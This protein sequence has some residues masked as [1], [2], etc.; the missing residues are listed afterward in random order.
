MIWFA[1]LLVSGLSALNLLLHRDLRHPAVI[2]SGLW[3]CILTAAWFNSD[4]LYELS[5]GSA[6]AVLL[7]VSAFSTGSML[8]SCLLRDA[9][10][11]LPVPRGSIDPL[12][13]TL[14]SI[15]VYGGLPFYLYGAYRLGLDGPF[16]EHLR[17]LR[18]ALSYTGAGF[19]P[20]AYLM[21]LSFVLLAAR[22]FDVCR[23]RNR[24][25]LLL[26]LCA[27]TLYAL[28]STGRGPVFQIL[29]ILIGVPLICGRLSVSRGIAIFLCLG[30]GTFAVLGLALKK[31]GSFDQGLIQNLES[32]L[33]SIRVYALGGLLAFGLEVQAQI[34][35]VYGLNTFRTLLAVLAALG[36]DV[37]VQQLVREFVPISAYGLTNVY[38]V[39]YA[40][41]QDFGWM[42]IVLSQLVFGAWHTLLYR[43]AL[44]G[45][46]VFSIL[47]AMFLFP[48]FMQFF[49]DSY[50]SLMSY[51]LQIIAASMLLF[52]PFTASAAAAAET[53]KSRYCGI[54]PRP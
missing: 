46:A 32:L 20:A 24:W 43:Q 25:A 44:Q 2:Q 34:Q 23:G 49:Q 15:L 3:L 5:P 1:L 50:F 12:A 45:A 10:A 16:E 22:L 26:P 51:W 28:L 35:L 42:G 18:Y 52:V 47:Y 54:I 36:F 29:C 31:G 7:G 40:Y 13:V 48:L 11:A 33:I 37:P 9:G 19:G 6:A 53:I 8:V 41:F 21:P 27:A 17:N 30:L 39:F 14:I 38:T 4:I